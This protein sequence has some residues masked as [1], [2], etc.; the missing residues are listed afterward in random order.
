MMSGK[1]VA[2]A[3]QQILAKNDFSLNGMSRFYSIWQ[4]ELG[5]ELK[6]QY[7]A[8]QNVLLNERRCRAAVNWASQDKG[9]REIFM[10]FLTGQQTYRQLGGNMA[11]QYLRC[12]IKDKLKCFTKPQSDLQFEQINH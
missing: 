3:C 12:K 7:F 6:F 2:D 9:L 4:K 1:L 10:K 8:F 11:W 5:N